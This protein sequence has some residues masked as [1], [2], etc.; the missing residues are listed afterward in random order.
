[1]AAGDPEGWINPKSILVILAHPDDPE[2]FLGGS[3]AHWV[4]NGHQ[5]R[6]CLF[7]RGDKGV[8][9]KYVDPQELARQRENEQ[10]EAAAILGVTSVEFLDY[11]DGFLTP[12]LDTRREIVRVIRRMKPDIVV[13]SDPTNFFFRENR[14]NHPDHRAAGLIVA[15]AVYPACGNPLFF[16][17][18]REEGLE[19]HSVE[20]L[21]FSLPRPADFSIDVSATW[22]LKYQSL[23]KHKSQIKDPDRLYQNLLNRRTAESSEENP[24]F[25]EHFRRIIFR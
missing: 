20:E 18:M 13:T 8:D 2:F 5:V 3:I 22:N 16:P 9:G 11:E 12:S 7:T 21:W 19:P 10:R 23:L 1:M 25:V 17:E 15:D 6:Y 4:N 14:L 24:R